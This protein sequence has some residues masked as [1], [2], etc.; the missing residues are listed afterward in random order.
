[1]RGA[2]ILVAAAVVGCASGEVDPSIYD[3]K[4]AGQASA[5]CA[6]RAG[7]YRAT[8]TEE[9]GSC[10][11]KPEQISTISKQ[12]TSADL[13]AMGCS[14]SIGYSADNCRVTSDVKCTSGDT[15]VHTVGVYDWSADGASATG[16][17]QTTISASGAACSSVYG[18]SMTRL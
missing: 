14:G 7:T 5:D 10:G 13:A 2:A 18:V 6:Q 16:T 9:S 17:E 3:V 1:M 4:P 12:P 8:Y 11:Q 15:T